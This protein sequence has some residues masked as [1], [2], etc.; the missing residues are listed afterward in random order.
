M[1]KFLRNQQKRSK[2]SLSRRRGAFSIKLGT[3]GMCLFAYAARRRCQRAVGIYQPVKTH[4]EN[5]L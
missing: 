4:L 1:R 3:D 2:C 5:V